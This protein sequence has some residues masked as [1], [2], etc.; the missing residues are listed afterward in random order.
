MVSCA[1]GLCLFILEVKEAYL[2][3]VVWIGKAPSLGDIG[4]SNFVT[5]IAA[6]S[7]LRLAAIAGAAVVLPALGSQPLCIAL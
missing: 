6:L 1:P 4:L 5:S 7:I 2:V 3:N